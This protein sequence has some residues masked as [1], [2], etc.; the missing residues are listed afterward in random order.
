MKIS[1]MV[2][3]NL[4]EANN[5]SDKVY[6]YLDQYYDTFGDIFPLMQF[7]GTDDEIIAEIRKCI[8]NNKPYEI[9]DTDKIF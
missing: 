2:K 3:C 1:K 4:K 6:E 9:D 5:L 7:S 8:I